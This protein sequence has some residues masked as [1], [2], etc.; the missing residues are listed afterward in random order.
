MSEIF[1]RSLSE[2]FA[3]GTTYSFRFILAIIIFVAGWIVA[4]I[5]SKILKQILITSDIDTKIAKLFGVEAKIEKG[6]EAKR[7]IAVVIEKIFYVLLVLI[8]LLFA[9]QMLGDEVISGILKSIFEKIGV[10]LPDVL[11]AFLILAI[12]WA[13]AFVIRFVIVGGLSKLRLWERLSP[14]FP[15]GEG[16]SLEKLNENIGSVVFYLIILVALMPFF[17]ALKMSS[18][19][20]PLKAMF[21]KVFAYIPNLLTGVIIIVFGFFVARLVEKIVTGFA[22]SAGINRYIESLPFD[23]VLKSLDFAKMVGTLAFLFIMVPI[24]AVAFESMQIQILTTVLGTFMNKF[25][26]ALPNVIAGFF[27]FIIGLVVGRFVGDL[28]AKILYDLGLDKLLL[29]IG[30]ENLEKKLSKKETKFSL[31]KIGGN[32]VAIVVMLLFLMEALEL[33]HFDLLA[34]AIDKLILYLPHILVA[35][36]LIALGFYLA[37]ILEDLVRKS[38][39]AEK[40]FEADLI[41]LGLRYGV[42]VFAFF[43]AFDQLK[44]AHTIVT[45]AF[46]ILLGTVGL[47]FALAFGLGGQSFAQNYIEHLKGE[48]K[49]KKEESK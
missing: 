36:V 32:L 6:Q 33:M 11:K 34:S 25:A 23:T 37:K 15:E 41:G 14:L 21:D 18:L 45:S 30:A 3:S 39:S 2:F 20:S 48:I 7:Q 26:S 49:K 10:A 12:A 29:S 16:K 5:L 38:F 42:I 43:M 31:A 40:A 17:E 19:V 24:V 4:K 22:E 8:A 46:I 35:F 27:L 1:G 28:T 13:I 9:L 47:A 44:I